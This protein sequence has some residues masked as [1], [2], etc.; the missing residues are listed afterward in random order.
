MSIVLR[1]VVPGR[2][3]RAGGRCLRARR[4]AAE[5]SGWEREGEVVGGR[6]EGTLEVLPYPRSKD[7]PIVCRMF[8]L[9]L[10]QMHIK[11]L[12][13]TRLTKFNPFS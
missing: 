10:L 12:D 8:L 3:F 13:F 7:L 1:E 5:P 9:F 4:G 11:L 2:A 6:S